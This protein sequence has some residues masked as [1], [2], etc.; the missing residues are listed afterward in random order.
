MWN[1]VP[2][3]YDLPTALMFCYHLKKTVAKSHVEAHGGHAHGKSQWFKKS[4]SGDFDVKKE[5]R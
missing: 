1:F 2:K 5:E 3:N 4:K